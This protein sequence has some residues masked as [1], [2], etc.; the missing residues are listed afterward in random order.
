MSRLSFVS[1]LAL[2]T[3]AAGCGDALPPVEKVIEYRL[4]AAPVRVVEPHEPEA[5]ADGYVAAEALP[6]ERVELTAFAVGPDGPV[7]PEALDLRWIA[8][9]LPPGG[10]VFSCL[11]QRFP[12]DLDALP[13]C[14]FPDLDE[15]LALGQAPAFGSPCLLA[16]DP[17][18]GFEVP[19]SEGTLSGSSLELTAIGTTPEGTS[20]E[21]CAQDLLSGKA[22][23]PN[24]CVYGVQVVSVGPEQRLLR[25]LSS[26]GLADVD[27]PPDDEVDPVDVHPRIT[28]FRVSVLGE[29]DEPVGEAVD[30]SLG[31]TVQARVGQRLRIET[32]SPE[33]DLQEYRYPVNSGAAFETASEQYTGQWFI[34]WG[35]LLSPESVDAQS[36]N[37]WTL[38]AA[39][40]DAGRPPGDVAHLYYVV[41]D[42][43]NGAAHWWISL[44]F[45]EEGEG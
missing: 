34:T 25:W 2:V 36:Y 3:L 39:E 30:V 7:E 24:D 31:G 8:C 10:G 37:E 27:A 41:R 17:S 13:T 38:E 26:A 29:D 9:E 40:D 6:G 19:V 35:A 44:A 1:S 45:S 23:L 32:T 18:E 43:R 20:F 5:I 14:D 15:V 16:D 22:D 28:R 4:L 33:D 21:R 42:G 11:A 12:L